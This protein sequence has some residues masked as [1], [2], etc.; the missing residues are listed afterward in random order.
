MSR[1]TITYHGYYS[2]FNIIFPYV[3]MVSTC[4]EPQLLIMDIILYLTSFSPM[5]R[6][7]RYVENHNCLSW[8]LWYIVFNI[9]LTY[10]TVFSTCRQPQFLIMDIILY[11]PYVT[12]VSTC[13][14][15]HFLILHIILYLT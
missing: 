14:E 9:I 7:Y 8:I 13:R 6:W 5:L 12:V 15:P 4:R 3:S 10:V 11:F 2:E 1:T